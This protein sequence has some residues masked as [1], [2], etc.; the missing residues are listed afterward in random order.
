MTDVLDERFAALADPTDDGDWLDVRRRARR[1]HGRLLLAAAAAVAGIAA[2]AAL[3]ATDGWIFSR[4]GSQVTGVTHVSFHGHTWT[5]SVSTN[6]RSRFCTHA[7]STC[8]GPFC[9]KLTGPRTESTCGIYLVPLPGK[10]GTTPLVLVV[11]R[12]LPFGALR[13]RDGAGELWF[14]EAR[15]DVRRIVI[16]DGRGHAFTARTVAAPASLRTTTRF[17]VLPLP[18]SYARTIAAYSA[19]GGL[20]KRAKVSRLYWI[21]HP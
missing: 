11:R 21:R 2:V 1:P 9:A 16:S 19:S 18:A 6:G 8:G 17:W 7:D 5:V 4:S 10:L 12:P 14:G 20:V 15:A 3:A 13:L